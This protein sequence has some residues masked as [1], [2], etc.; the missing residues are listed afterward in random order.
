MKNLKKIVAYAAMLIFSVSAVGC[1]M[2][3]KT[4]EAI[5][6]T[7][8]AKV[9]DAKI[10]RGELDENYATKMLIEQ[11]KQKYGES[12]N[13]NQEAK[14]LLKEQKLQIL[15]QMTMEKA[16]I[17]EAEKLKVVPAEAELNKEIKAKVE[18]FKK[19]QGISD[20][21]AYEA[22]LKQ[23]GLT[24]KT[25]EELLKNNIIIEKYH[26]EVIKAAKVEDKE[27]QEYYNKF[28]DKYPAK[29]KEPTQVQLAHILVATEQEAKEI[30][31]KVDKG[32]DFAALAKQYGT[33]GTKEKGGDLG[34]IP[35][36]NSGF[37]EDF[38]E[39]AMNLK[40]GEVSNPV[41][42]Q[43]GYHLIKMVKKES[44]PVKTF[45]QAKEQV[46]KDLL[47]KK[48]NEVWNK[49][50]TDIKTNAKIKVYEEKVV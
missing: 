27:A 38:M 23:N 26:D 47:S 18:E 40:D 39:G 6:K 3:E 25:F 50:L 41:K 49:K 7:T 16:V 44:K 28:K 36:V 14:E 42:T 34:T 33:D 20:D 37:D 35:V 11:V 2:I 46:K 21:K 9:G 30:K 1:N 31:A 13:E 32:E 8:I 15:E 19:G 22:A 48:Q 29:E 5:A 24:T 17:Q 4:P 45:E 10:T 12:Y 43:F